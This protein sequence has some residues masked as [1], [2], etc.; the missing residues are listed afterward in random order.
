MV[1]NYVKFLNIGFICKHTHIHTQEHV[2]HFISLSDAFASSN[3]IKY[4]SKIILKY[5]HKES[6]YKSNFYNSDAIK[7]LVLIFVNVSSQSETEQQNYFPAN[8]VRFEFCTLQYHTLLSRYCTF[9][10]L[11]ISYVLLINRSIIV[12]LLV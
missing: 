1:E 11:F 9:V 4:I 12:C 5:F 3:I 2:W 10:K 6:Q 8:Y 7:L